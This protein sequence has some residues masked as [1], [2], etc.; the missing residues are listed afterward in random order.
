M[1]M[2]F[3]SPS[4]DLRIMI[5]L[6]IISL[7]IAIATYVFSKRIL[8]SVVIFSVFS[9]F[10]INGNMDYNYAKIFNLMW[11]FKL[12]RNFLPYINI[13]LVCLLIFNFFKKN[14]AQKK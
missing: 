7:A 2:F 14:E 5:M 3:S 8:L 6:L 9:Q 10:I 4:A 11:L 12:S 1:N 13:A